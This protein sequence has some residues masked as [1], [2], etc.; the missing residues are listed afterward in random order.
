MPDPVID[1][2]PKTPRRGKLVMSV[3][4]VFVLLLLAYGIYMALGRT[5][6]TTKVPDATGFTKGSRP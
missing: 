6:L 5:V 2:A 3:L 1:P 4:F